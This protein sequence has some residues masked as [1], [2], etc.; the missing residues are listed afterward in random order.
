MRL[1]EGLR[2]PRAF[3][4]SIVRSL[5]RFGQWDSRTDGYV[6]IERW[7]VRRALE[8]YRSTLK[9]IRGRM[10]AEPPSTVMVERATIAWAAEKAE[11]GYKVRQRHIG[12]IRPEMRDQVT[13]WVKLGKPFPTS[14]GVY[15]TVPNKSFGRVEELAKYPELRDSV[16]HLGLEEEWLN[17]WS[18]YLPLRYD[19]SNQL[20]AMLKSRVDVEA[21]S[22][23]NE[24]AGT[25]LY[26]RGRRLKRKDLV[27]YAG[28]LDFLE[29]YGFVMGA[30]FAACQITPLEPDQVLVVHP[31]DARIKGAI[32]SRADMDVQG[33][34][35][36]GEHL[37]VEGVSQ[38]R[39]AGSDVSGLLTNSFTERKLMQVSVTEKVLREYKDPRVHYPF[40]SKDKLL[41]ALALDAKPFKGKRYII[42][43]DFGLME[44][45]KSPADALFSRGYIHLGTKFM[46]MMLSGSSWTQAVYAVFHKYFIRKTN[47]ADEMLAL[48]DD[49]NLLTSETTDA[50][51]SPYTKVKS[52]D[53]VKNIKKVLGIF[54]AFSTEEDVLGERE[55]T[56]GIV[57]RIIKSVSSAAKRGSYWEE[58]LSDLPESGTLELVPD[59]AASETI[60]RDLPILRKYSQWTG[61]RAEVPLMLRAL[62]GN[63]DV[64]AWKILVRYDPD[65]EYRLNPEGDEEVESVSEDD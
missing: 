9:G 47:T 32:A 20:L 50:I 46:P 23:Q 61:R 22:R 55:A 45:I 63:I 5:E 49:M 18:I 37:T 33:V 62:W 57:P 34:E 17:F 65:M 64:E 1:E 10:E 48:G 27:D 56:F 51:F 60:R 42:G 43:E 41:E 3:I 40:S 14:G 7:P 25:G 36:D 29:S 21:L 4:E 24:E 6:R 11:I 58:S 19:V 35:W 15:W 13:K 2:S 12:L 39:Q 53:P 28:D 26:L 44:P 54:T 52:T 16:L 38:T 8:Q 30:A 31:Y 59:P